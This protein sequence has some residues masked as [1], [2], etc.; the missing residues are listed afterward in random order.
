MGSCLAHCSAWHIV[1]TQFI[2]VVNVVLSA[3]VCVC[4]CELFK[5]CKTKFEV[6]LYPRKFRFDVL[7]I[8]ILIS[9]KSIHI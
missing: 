4:V 2:A 1:S 5:E 9:L 8:Y 6:I 3:Y 7:I